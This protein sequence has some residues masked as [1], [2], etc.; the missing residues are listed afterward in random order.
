M[1]LSGS[2]TTSTWSSSSGQTRGYTVGWYATQDISQNKSYI[3]WTL[4]TAGT[5]PYTVAERTLYVTVADQVVV[6]KTDRVM[7]GAG[8][9]ASGCVEVPH[10]SDGTRSFAISIQ[11]AVYTSSINC[12]GSDWFQLNTIPRQATL[13][14]APNFT[15]EQNPTITYQ[16]LAGNSVDALY[17]CIS[18]TGSTDDVPYRSISKT[19]SSYTFNLTDAERTTL[20]NAT[21]SGAKTRLVYFYVRTVIGGVKYHSKIQVTLTIANCTPTIT[22]A[23]VTDTNES[24]IALTGDS[25]VIVL[26]ASTASVSMTPTYKKGA[27]ASTQKVTCGSKSISGTSGTIKAPASS[28]FVFSVT[29]NRG[30]AASKTVTPS[31][32]SYIAPSC[33]LSAGAPN[34]EGHLEFTLSGQCF[35]GSFGSVSNTYTLQYRYKE[36]GG[37]YGDWT[38][39]TVTPAS[40]KYSVAVT[41]ESLDYTKTYTLQAQFTDVINTAKSNDVSVKTSTIFDW[42]KKDFN[43]NVP[44]KFSSG[45]TPVVVNPTSSAYKMMNL[46]SGVY[47][48]SGLGIGS[49]IPSSEHGVKF[50]F[51]VLKL[52]IEGVYF[53]HSLESTHVWMYVKTSSYSSG[54]TQIVS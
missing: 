6:N 19:G 3:Y 20:R 47:Y 52:S 36:S 35:V 26:N 53:F 24:T 8:D 29:D 41:L 45:F 32:I 21:L 42:S 54:W 12:T 46:P 5:Y 51:V 43:F 23:T 18:L 7:R 50:M 13:T 17:A 28:S 15:D 9:I 31:T 34:A 25:S 14:S 49:D 44:V 30:Q 40:N 48:C 38:A 1:S 11:G 16:N 2:V 4:S 22:A 37:E 39:V 27:S 33:V 10:G